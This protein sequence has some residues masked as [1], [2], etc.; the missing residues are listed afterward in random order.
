LNR[1]V[2]KPNHL[3]CIIGSGCHVLNTGSRDQAMHWYGLNH[4]MKQVHVNVDA[5]I[6][7]RVT[8]VLQVLY[9]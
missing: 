5:R 2:L 9:N 6:E 8:C 4:C 7:D 1:E 3:N